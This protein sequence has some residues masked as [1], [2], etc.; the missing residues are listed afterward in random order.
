MRKKD[1]LM[2]IILVPRPDGLRPVRVRS[3][4]AAALSLGTAGVVTALLFGVFMSVV[5][6]GSLFARETAAPAAIRSA[7]HYS[8]PS[9]NHVGAPVLLPA[10]EV[11]A[12]N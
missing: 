9:D 4:L 7:P 10:V 1:T 11:I 6:T 12:S 8:T 3:P 2:H 5:P